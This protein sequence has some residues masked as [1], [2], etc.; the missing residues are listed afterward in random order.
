MKIKMDKCD[1]ILLAA[2]GTMLA[3]GVSVV[4]THALNGM[5]ALFG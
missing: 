2:F 5:A 1:W 4:V 3:V